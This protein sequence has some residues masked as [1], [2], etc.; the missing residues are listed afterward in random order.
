MAFTGDGTLYVAD[1]GGNRLLAVAPDHTVR[2]V[3]RLSGSPFGV[4]I[5]PDSNIYVS[6][7]RKGEVD[8]V[9]P[10]GAVT[11]YATVPPGAGSVP[12][13]EGLAFD[14]AG[15]LYVGAGAG[16]TTNA[17][18]GSTGH[19]VR[20]PPG[21]GA[22][23]ELVAG[24]SG[25]LNLAFA[26]G[27]ALLYIAVQGEGAGST[28]NEVTTHATPLP[29]LPV[30][31]PSIKLTFL[32][33]EAPH[34]AVF[35]AGGFAQDPT[36]YAGQLPLPYIADIGFT[37]S[38][39]S[40][41]VSHS[42]AVYMNGSSFAN[43]P[44][45]AFGVSKLRKS[46]DGGRT[47]TDA[48][49][50]FAGQ[51]NTSSP[52]C[53]LDPYLYYDRGPG[54][55]FHGD[56]V[57]QCTYFSSTDNDGAT[58]SPSIPCGPAP[59]DDHETLAGGPPPAGTTTTG[60]GNALYYC[61]QSV[62]YNGCNQSL[63]GGASFS[64]VPGRPYMSGDSC[65]NTD[66]LQLGNGGQTGH[67]VV[68]SDGTVYLPKADCGPGPMVAISHDGGSSWTQS[69]VHKQTV[70]HSQDHESAVALDS[71]EHAYYVW[72]DGATHIPYLAVSY[73]RGEHWSDRVFAIAP[74]GVTEADQPAIIAGAN[75]RIAVYFYGTTGDCCYGRTSDSTKTTS[76]NVAGLPSSPWNAYV[77]MSLNASA[78][79]P[80][81]ISTPMN[82]PRRPL[83]RGNCGPG[84]C[85][86]SFDFWDVVMDDHGRTWTSITNECL[87]SECAKPGL[88][89][90]SDGVAEGFAG[91]LLCGPRI[92]TVGVLTPPGWSTAS[93][94]VKA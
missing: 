82:E 22:A 21:G 64:I 17:T 68:G 65:E 73:D 46:V 7:L 38:E 35:G 13:A 39:P 69:L 63:D 56:L 23:S 66:F 71:A 25:P 51:H 8:R 6:L 27:S 15:G 58:W 33:A 86:N 42:G 67:V 4:A 16:D 28:K 20:V 75:G 89:G 85:S 34:A 12:D 70:F 5:G 14:S 57:G 74:P 30:A 11:L 36:P 61:W 2:S 92:D 3:A 18:P 24:L 93:C 43:S 44:C 80:T 45:I 49:P 84:R 72:V 77:V 55:L 19:V 32:P 76:D 48:T 91:Q 40:I 47:F 60:Y 41:G 10:G 90:T 78:P 53:T 62:A 52:P 81:F 26:P 37:A 50:P 94:G 59:L 88:T 29:G 83:I 31:L 79:N 9:T 87:T 1:A 54:R